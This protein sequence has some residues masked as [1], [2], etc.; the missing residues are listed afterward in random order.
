V[1]VQDG[2][3]QQRVDVKT[4]IVSTDRVEMIDGL[5]EGQIIVSP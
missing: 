1:V 5:K 2:S 3:M 4:G